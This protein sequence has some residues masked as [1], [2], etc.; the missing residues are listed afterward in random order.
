MLA[1]AEALKTD[2]I[3]YWQYWNKKGSGWVRYKYGADS[4]GKGSAFLIHVIQGGFTDV[5][6]FIVSPL[7]TILFRSK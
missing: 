7:R 6:I 4:D 3:M 1:V 2:L 5:G